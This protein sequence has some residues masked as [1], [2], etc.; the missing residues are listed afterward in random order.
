VLKAALSSPQF[1]N[2]FF[3]ITRLQPFK[4]ASA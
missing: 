4:G 3:S 2:L 1:S